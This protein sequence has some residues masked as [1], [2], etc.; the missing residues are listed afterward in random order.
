MARPGDLKK[1]EAELGWAPLPT[2]IFVADCSTGAV[3][4]REPT[5][6]ERAGWDEERGEIGAQLAEV[7]AAFAAAEADRTAREAKVSKMAEA[8]GLTLEELRETL[9]G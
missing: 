2:V 5:S 7:A 9:V 3:T 1:L 8:A 6:D 4:E